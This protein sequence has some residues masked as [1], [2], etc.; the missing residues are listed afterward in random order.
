MGKFPLGVGLLVFSHTG[1][2]VLPIPLLESSHGVFLNPS[3]QSSHGFSSPGWIFAWKVE[4][5]TS[6]HVNSNWFE[7]IFVL[8]LI[9]A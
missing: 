9:E 6:R 5:D 8:L 2:L 4:G 7:T 1:V 3:L